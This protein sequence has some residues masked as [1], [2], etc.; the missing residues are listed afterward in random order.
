MYFACTHASSTF[1]G[2][3]N[4]TS[5]VDSY[6]DPQILEEY[7]WVLGRDTQH[8]DHVF[9]LDGVLLY[10]MHFLLPE[11]VPPYPISPIHT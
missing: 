2:L 6:A 1:L 10:T 4:I 5:F 3:K 8:D 9:E 7:I 11:V